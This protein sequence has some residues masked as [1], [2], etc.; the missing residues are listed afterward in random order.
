MFVNFSKFSPMV[1]DL[2]EDLLGLLRGLMLVTKLMIVQWWLLGVWMAGMLVLV[3]EFQNLPFRQM[4]QIPYSLKASLLIVNAE[5][6]LVSLYT[7]G[8]Y[9]LCVSQS[10]PLCS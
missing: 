10:K 9:V 8:L 7:L 1:L 6:F 2:P 4:P 5:K 3:V